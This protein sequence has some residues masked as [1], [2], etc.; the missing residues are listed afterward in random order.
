[1]PEDIL[2][3]RA[4][5]VLKIIDGQRRVAQRQ[6]ELLK[7]IVNRVVELEEEA[8]HEEKVLAGRNA[9]LLLGTM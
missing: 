3:E 5:K 9:L 6:A 2:E 7:V 8:A 1:M 4:G